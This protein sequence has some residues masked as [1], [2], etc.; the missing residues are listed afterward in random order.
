MLDFTNKTKMQGFQ[1]NFDDQQ[2]DQREDETIVVDL[3]PPQYHVSPPRSPSPNISKT[4]EKGKCEIKYLSD[5]PCFVVFACFVFMVCVNDLNFENP[6]VQCFAVKRSHWF[7]SNLTGFRN[8]E[9]I[10]VIIGLNVT[11]I[12]GLLL[13]SNT[14]CLHR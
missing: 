6:A 7:Y 8:N 3:V 10:S 13:M 11:R 1:R 9:S 12:V 2:R 5:I 4:S 14:A